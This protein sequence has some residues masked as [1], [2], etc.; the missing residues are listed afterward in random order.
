MPAVHET[1][2]SWVLDLSTVDRNTYIK[3]HRLSAAA[4]RALRAERRRRKNRTYA[5]CSRRR[6]KA[7]KLPLRAQVRMLVDKVRAGGAV[8]AA[9]LRSLGD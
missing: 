1:F 5:A 3:E 4:V 9:E 6:A 2:P 7:H 8:S